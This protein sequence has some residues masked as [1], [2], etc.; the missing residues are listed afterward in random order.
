MTDGCLSLLVDPQFKKRPSRP[1]VFDPNA[2]PLDLFSDLVFRFTRLMHWNLK[3]FIE[4]LLVFQIT[5][6]MVHSLVSGPS[7]K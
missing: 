1:R 3:E 7:S 4:E 2:P 6:I 5:V